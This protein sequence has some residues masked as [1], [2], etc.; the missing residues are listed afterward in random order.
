MVRSKP[1]SEKYS[2]D[3]HVLFVTKEHLVYQFKS[4][5]FVVDLR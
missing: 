2:G 4:E 5:A 3:S 1:V